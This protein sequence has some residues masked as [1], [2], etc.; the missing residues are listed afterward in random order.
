[1]GTITHDMHVHV[2]YACDLI[3]IHQQPSYN[4]THLHC[5]FPEIIID[6][7]TKSI[8]HDIVCVTAHEH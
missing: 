8:I 5:E 2:I 7:R 6:L 1:M 4:T 3:H